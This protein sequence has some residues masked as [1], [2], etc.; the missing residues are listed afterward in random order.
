MA[1]GLHGAIHATATCCILHSRNGRIHVIAADGLCSKLLGQSQPVRHLV[2][3]KHL[4]AGIPLAGLSGGA[5]GFRKEWQTLNGAD[6]PRL[7]LE[8]CC[9][10][11]ILMQGL[12]ILGNVLDLPVKGKGQESQAGSP[13]DNACLHE[14]VSHGALPEHQGLLTMRF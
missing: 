9:N 8:A 14:G 5:E 1:H 3:C 10:A 4:P 12:T 2:N 6:M 13:D 7:H 11:K